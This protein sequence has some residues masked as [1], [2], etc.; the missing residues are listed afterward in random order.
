MT[1]D[2]FHIQPS[3]RNGEATGNSQGIHQASLTIRGKR[4]HVHGMNSGEVCR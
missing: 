3:D 2:R 4:S 1:N